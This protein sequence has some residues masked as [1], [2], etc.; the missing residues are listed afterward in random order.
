ML[1]STE[2]TT[3]LDALETAIKAVGLAHYVVPMADEFQSEYVPPYAA[4]L[5]HVTGFGGS[6]GMGVFGSG[7]HTLFVDGRYVLQAPQQ[8]DTTRV[9]VVNSG[10]VGFADWLKQQNATGK[11]G[12][13]AWLVTV[14]QLERW[15]KATASLPLEW[16]ATDNLVDGMWPERPTLPNA[17][18]TLQPMQFAGVSYADKRASL[19]ETMTQMKADALLLTAGDSINWLL[20][21]RGH[22]VEFNPLL[23]G[24]YL[25]RADGSATLYSFPREWSAEVKSYLDAENVAIADIAEIFAGKAPTLP[26]GTRLM[27]D[28]A[29]T[30]QGWA[31]LADAKGW[32]L[33]PETDPT[34]LPKALKNATELAAIRDAHRRDGLALTRFLAWLDAQ[35][36]AGRAVDEYAVD[37]KLQEFRAMDA[38]YRG[39][40]FATIAGAG[41]NGAIVHYRADQ[42]TARTLRRGEL[43]L[44][45]SGGQ[46]PGGTTDVTRTI[47]LPISAKEGVDGLA[48]A[49]PEHLSVKDRFTR[50]LKGH[51]AIATAKFPAGT[52][53]T[54]LDVL[55][56]QFLWE[57]GLDY[58][59]GT[60]HGV[61]AYLCVHEGPQRISKRSSDVAL[62]PGMILSNEP[63]YYEAGAYGIRIE[64]LVEVVTRETPQVGRAYL[65]FETLT[66]APIDTRLVDIK[67]L[68][69][70]ER[71]WLN[72]YHRRVFEA[73]AAQLD[74]P[75][76]AWLLQATRAI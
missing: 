33:L 1:H 52:S 16:V 48:N 56:R 11:I 28:P 10:E 21:M 51:I 6:A 73:H 13:D 30:P 34:Q 27:A 65:G 45:D 37:A 42:K 61:G 17:P 63:G 15:K 72:A 47:Y 8:I 12:F 68:T 36:A 62:K 26:K 29:Q 75:V 32:E 20:N 55:A 50:V 5:A 40:S 46:Y 71:N 57:A 38:D 22:D 54:Q 43:L 66:L 24:Y 35:I 69:M 39:P 9:S 2:S 58:D 67:L 18:A 4:R 31:A 3:A 25:L 19:L 53:G 23:L 64:S 7:M 41:P 76:R 60:G 14:Q 44:L 74:T 49:T 59:H 70:A